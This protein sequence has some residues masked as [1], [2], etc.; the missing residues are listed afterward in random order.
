MKE[1]PIYEEK[2]YLGY[3]RLSQ[4]RRLLLMLFCFGVYWWKKMNGRNGDLFFWLGVGIIIVSILLLFVLHIRIRLYRDRL[5]L[6]GLW[7][8][9]PVVI[10][11]K[12]IRKVV[13]TR[14]SKY[15]LNNPVFNLKWRNE[16]RFY[17]DGTEAIEV[18]DEKGT[19]FRIGSHSAGQLEQLLK[20][21]TRTV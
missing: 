5:E 17:T 11:V 15:H 4:L 16:V 10:P 2:Q 13:R 8:G 9:K 12:D 19:P 18:V 21:F 1:Q 7:S 3:N 20:D 6:G 14:Y